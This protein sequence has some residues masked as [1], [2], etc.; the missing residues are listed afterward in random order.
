M[1]HVKVV[2]CC[3]SLTAGGP[4]GA[5]GQTIAGRLSAG[6]R[7]IRA[8]QRNLWVACKMLYFYGVVYVA[9]A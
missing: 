6:N 7:G 3:R 5:Y 4:G 1:L 2:L 8:A 9:G